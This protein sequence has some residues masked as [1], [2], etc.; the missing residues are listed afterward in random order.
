MS[1][2]GIHINKQRWKIVLAFLVLLVIAGTLIVSNEF[3]SKIGQREKDKAKQW[4]QSV[5]KKGELVELSNQIFLELKKKEKQ[6]IDLVVKAQKTILTKSDL[7]QNQDIEFSYSIIESNNDIPVVLLIGDEVSQY[8]NMDSFFTEGLTQK[9]KDS[10]CLL[11]ADIW[12]GNGQFYE[13]E[14]YEGMFLQ[15]IYGTSL[16]LKR[17]QD[18]SKEL[19]K[20]FNQEIKD[21]QGLIPVI[22][23]DDQKDI[24]VAT[25]VNKSKEALI[26]LKD[27]WKIKN[28]P[29]VFNFDSG[30]KILYYSDS[31]E[32]TY[33]QWIP[34]FQFIIL[35]LIILL[36]Y[37]I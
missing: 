27:Q 2:K 30:K 19:I 16:E 20:S 14:Y 21:N 8:R 22:L 31:R 1:K 33:L 26:E 18:E 24:L 32:L 13:I 4:A 28:P 17:L 34:Y 10:I 5:K 35:G 9:E 12:K 37:F 23:W 29:I 25:N 36:G 15:F 7:G 11:K 6:K 3:I